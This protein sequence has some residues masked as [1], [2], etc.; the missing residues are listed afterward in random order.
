MKPLVT[1]SVVLALAVVAA[2]CRGPACKSQSECGIGSHCVLSVSGSSV[3]GECVSE[4]VVNTD[5]VGDDTNLTV[6]ICTNEGRCTKVTRKPR[7]KVFT[8]EH[9]SLLEE[10]TRSVRLEG[11]VSSAAEMVTISALQEQ[12]HC[13]LGVLQTAVV[14][15]AEVGKM[16]TIPWVI[17]DVELVPGLNRILVRANVGA[18]FKQV[19]HLLEVPC[20]GCADITIQAP[21]PPATAPALE[22]GRLSGLVDPPSVKTAVWRVRGDAGDVFNGSVPV[23]DGRFEAQGL[24]L[25]AGT[26]RVEVVVSGVGSGL[27]EARCSVAVA[28]GLA[29]ERGI[30]AMLTWD[31]ATS[32]LDL[33]IVGPGG[34]YLD[35]QTSLSSRSKEPMNFSGEVIDDLEGFGPETATVEAPPDGVYGFVVSPEFDGDDPGSNATLRLVFDGRPVTR[36]ALGPQYL[37]A[38]IQ[39][40]IWVV[41]VLHIAGGAASWTSINR[42]I[43][44]IS[45]PMI[46][47]EDWVTGL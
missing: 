25:F 12:A 3:N 10:G 40:E 37:S 1:L 16:V 31:G 29:R 36:G 35:R 18:T 5:C 23:L 46:P 8:P 14:R 17:E 9:D 24:P 30:R 19:N 45:A 13:S 38:D 20:P 27:G 11:E 15:N 44:R 28:S 7:L 42:L 43:S 26:N 2:G 22:L 4:C 41:G 34:T 39:R 32:D 21:T 33:H 6:P 47:P